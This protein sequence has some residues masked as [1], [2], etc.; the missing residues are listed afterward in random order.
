MAN[1]IDADLLALLTDTDGLYN[2][3]PQRDPSAMLIRRVDHIDSEI[4]RYAGASASGRGTGGMITKVQAA[5]LAT[6][7]GTDVVIAKGQEP[8]VLLRI[9]AGEEI[10]TLFPASTGRMESR[11][12]WMLTGLSLK[13]SLVIDSG[14]ARALR[15][16]AS[17]LFAR[18][19]NRG[20][21]Q[22]RARG[23]YRHRY[24]GRPGDGLW[25]C[26]L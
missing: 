20:A 12:R 19:C 8:D 5:R 16:S 15:A 18:R 4:E 11:K 1:L 22:L 21:R 9:A 10:G 6:T 13:G 2:A 3:D 17:S 14:A 7:G 25:H 23:R 26:E 24:R